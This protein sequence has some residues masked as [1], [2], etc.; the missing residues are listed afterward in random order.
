VSSI[1][2]SRE[3]EDHDGETGKSLLIIP[4]LVQRTI[5]NSGERLMDK[6]EFEELVLRRTHLVLERNPWW[7]G[8]EPEEG[9][10]GNG[11]GGESFLSDP[12]PYV[13]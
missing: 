10:P 9:G 8:K 1:W 11:L 12:R 6:M 7:G 5:Y 2:E 4:I 13:P 3:L